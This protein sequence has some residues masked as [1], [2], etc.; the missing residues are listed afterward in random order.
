[1]MDEDCNE[2]GEGGRC[3]W[4]GREVATGSPREG[5]ARCRKTLLQLS[6]ATVVI[7]RWRG[8]FEEAA[9]AGDSPSPACSSWRLLCLLL[10]RAQERERKEPARPIYGLGEGG[11]YKVAPLFCF[12]PLFSHFDHFYI[13]FS[14]SLRII[15]SSR[16]PFRTR[17]T[18]LLEV[19]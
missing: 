6:I 1:M 3:S 16:R 5:T 7:C 8:T 10:Q 9:A 12:S 4:E 19:S 2:R 11:D 13:V 14:I 15:K 18:K 17:S